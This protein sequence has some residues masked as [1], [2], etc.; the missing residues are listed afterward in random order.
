MTKIPRHAL[1][2]IAVLIALWLVLSGL[3]SGLLLTF[4][5]ASC[6]LVAYIALRMDVVDREGHPTHLN[7]LQL[8]RYWGWLGWQVVR[9][10]LDVV[11]RIL[12][13]KMPISPTVIRVRSSQ[14]TRLGQ[15][16]YANSITLTPGTVSINLWDGEI[17]VHALSKEG[18]EELRAGEMDR[19]VS[20][21]ETE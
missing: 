7:F 13:P 4:G 1:T 15:V 5:V 2:L 12:H 21:L 11:G 19:R 17:R 9:S 8:A 10:N 14:R 16:I 20:A 6:G 18:A 3:F